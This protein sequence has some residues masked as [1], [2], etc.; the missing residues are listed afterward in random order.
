M[1]VGVGNAAD[2]SND[3]F[4]GTQTVSLADETG[5]ADHITFLLGDTGAKED[6]H[7]I[8]VTNA[9]VEQGTSTASSDLV[10]AANNDADLDVSG[11]KAATLVINGGDALY[12]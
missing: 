11:V 3:I 5:S 7:A 6:V 4:K 12:L 8:L 10:D 2:A 9:A 1:T